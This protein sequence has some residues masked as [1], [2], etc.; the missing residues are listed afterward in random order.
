MKEGYRSGLEHKI[1][2]QL[3]SADV[4]WH[5]EPERIPYIPDQ[6]TYTPDFYLVSKKDYQY[7]SRMDRHG[8]F[9]E[10]KGRFIGSD[11]AK[12][13]LIKKQHP[14]LDIR[15]VFTNPNQKLYKGSRTTYG[16]WCE[17]HGFRYAKQDI[18]SEWII[19][20]VEE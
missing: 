13:L 20:M 8:I 18:P 5:Y 9:I 7:P 14:D 19:E 11:R 16:E 4:E 2:E 3:K 12:H 10:T 1:G 15:F 6:Q 17:K